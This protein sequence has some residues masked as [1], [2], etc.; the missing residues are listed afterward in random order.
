ME[1]LPFKAGVDERRVTS[2]LPPDVG[3]PVSVRIGRTT[4]LQ[5]LA[6]H[7]DSCD[8]KMRSRSSLPALNLGVFFS[9]ITTDSPDFGLRPTRSS[10]LA[11]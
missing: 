6:N 2:L 5:G 3:M 7:D 10:C 8:C 9:G 1:M 4:V 11:T